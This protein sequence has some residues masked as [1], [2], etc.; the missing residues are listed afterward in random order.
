MSKEFFMGRI[1][2][3]EDYALSDFKTKRTVRYGTKSE[4]YR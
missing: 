3:R 4:P 2:K 1:D